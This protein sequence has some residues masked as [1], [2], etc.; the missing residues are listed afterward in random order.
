MIRL[1]AVAVICIAAAF[2]QP[3][4][5]PAP[6]SLQ[7]ALNR[8]KQYNPQYGA[9][10]VAGALA[11]EDRVQARAGLA[12]A[13]SYLNQYIYTEGNGTPSGVFVANDGVH[14][15][16]SQGIAHE[17][18][19]LAKFAD[20]K[21]LIAA[22]AAARARTEIA[23]RGLTLTV[24]GNYYGLAVAQRK[25]ANARVS[26]DEAN[27]FVEITRKQEQ[28]GEV[29]HAD[30]VKA[31][32]TQQQR[33]RDLQ[34][35]QLAEQKARIALAILLFPDYRQNFNIVDDLNTV[36]SSASFTEVEAKAI[37]ASPE[38]REALS[39]VREQKY[40]LSSARAGYYPALSFDF[41]YGINANEFAIVG[42]DDR[43]NLG[44]SAQ[45]SLVIPVW[46]WGA[47]RSRVKQA[48]LLTKQADLELSAA[49]KA[50]AANLNSAYLEAQA[51]RTQVDSLKSS[52]SLSEESLR[53]TILRY[54]AGEATALEVVDAQST[55]ALARNAYDDGLS[56]YRIAWAT[57]E[58]LTGSL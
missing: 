37:A 30:V 14:V 16:S 50:L 25:M 36:A 44:Y 17:D 35:A 55:L 27:R 52:V 20:Y 31:E 15:Y 9:A 38:L 54:Q 1:T 56:R 34:D 28:G 19:S 13:L 5:A 24:V 21:R 32:L 2:G 53:L 41:F 40:A 39:N 29:A 23:A 8:A 7:E 58:T 48:N 33:A 51:A 22:E 18:L 10:V 12:P 46:N 3:V 11:H 6:I 49:R 47:T 26:L 4:P 57:L 45:G 43:H 42:P